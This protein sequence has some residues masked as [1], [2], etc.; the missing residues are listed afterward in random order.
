MSRK[1]S[2]IDLQNDKKGSFQMSKDFSKPLSIENV[3]IILQKNWTF[4][5]SQAV[6]RKTPSNN[7]RFL[8]IMT[9]TQ[10]QLDYISFEKSY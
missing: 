2:K 9:Y 10:N 1:T 6:L 7:L 5:N 4:N 3:D 8:K